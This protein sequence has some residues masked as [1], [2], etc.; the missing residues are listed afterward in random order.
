M[1][2]IHNFYLIIAIILS[3]NTNVIAKP[4]TAQF[5]MFV[6]EGALGSKQIL[7]GKY[8]KG[9]K[10]ITR[11]SDANKP[12][13]ELSAGACAANLMLN[14]LEQAHTD[15][16][17]AIQTIETKVSRGRK[18]RMFT[19]IAYSNRAVVRFK[20]GDSAGALADFS[21]ALQVDNNKFILKNLSV[22]KSRMAVHASTVD[23]MVSD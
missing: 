16:S 18:Y 21:K 19:S 22:F 14:R 12:H 13:F 3:C 10:K 8:Q 15:C 20:Q 1:K 23:Q 9:I 7:R 2:T 4:K 17:N 11:Y 6:L 5:E